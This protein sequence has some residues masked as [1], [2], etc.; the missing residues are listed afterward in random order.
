EVIAMAAGAEA[1]E[2]GGPCAVGGCAAHERHHMRHVVDDDIALERARGV[3]PVR[4]ELDAA[5]L[6]LIRIRAAGGAPVRAGNNLRHGA[7]RA[8]VARPVVAPRTSGD[9]GVADADGRSAG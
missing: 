1:A 2:G 5:R 9:A 3:V 4:P 6:A 8:E 7:G